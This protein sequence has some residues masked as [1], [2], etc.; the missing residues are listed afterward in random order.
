[1]AEKTNGSFGTNGGSHATTESSLPVSKGSKS[2]F[3]VGPSFKEQPEKPPKANR[4][5]IAKAFSQLAQW[6]H[7]TESPYPTQT[8]QGT[9]A[10]TK[11]PGLKQDLK[12][13]TKKGM[14]TSWR[15]RKRKDTDGK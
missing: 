10:V 1:M 4:E 6:V 9:F 13:M 8:G 7:A 5:G 15:R 12:A 11:G 14:S 2:T 3:G